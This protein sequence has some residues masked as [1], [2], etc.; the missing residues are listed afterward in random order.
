[1]NVEATF[2]S[3]SVISD[4]KLSQTVELAV[5]YDLLCIVY[6]VHVKSDVLQ[7]RE[8]SRLDN[9]FIPQRTNLVVSKI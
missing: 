9:G 7:M 5:V 6:F 8:L 3:K 2:A 4:R 1:L